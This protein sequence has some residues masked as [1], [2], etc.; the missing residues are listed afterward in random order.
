M[1]TPTDASSRAGHLRKGGQD[2]HPDHR[3]EEV[4]G[5]LGACPAAMPR[6]AIL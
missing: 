4:L 2:R 6:K 5:A 3:Q 1:G